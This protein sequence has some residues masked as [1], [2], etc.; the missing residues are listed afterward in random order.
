[1]VQ[2][3]TPPEMKHRIDFVEKII[4]L[5]ADA[6]NVVDQDGYITYVNRSFEEYH[7]V[8]KAEVVGKH[9]TE[10]IENTRMHIVAKSG[11]AEHDHLLTDSGSSYVVSRI[12]LIEDNECVGA[13]GLVRFRHLEEIKGLTDQI[14][15]LENELSD[16][17]TRATNPDTEY[18]FDLL[19]PISPKVRELKKQAMAVAKLDTTVLL[20]GESGTGKEVFAQSIHNYSPRR[21]GPFIYLNCSAIQENL[22]ES[23]LFGYDEG[24]FSGARKG[25]R[26]GMFELADGGT[27]FLD[28]IG[29]MPLSAQVKLLRVIQERKFIRLGSEKSIKVDVRIIAATNRDLEK[30]VREET[31]RSDLYFRLNVI[32]LHLPPLREVPEEIP[33]MAKNLWERLIRKNGMYHKILTPEAIVELQKHS[34]EGNVREL[35]NALERLTIMIPHDHIT[36]EDVQKALNCGGDTDSSENGRLNKPHALWEVLEETEKRT[37]TCALSVCDGNRSAAA[38]MLKISR[39]YLYKKMAKYQLG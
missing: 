25:G 38:K 21:E 3:M 35:R 28:E 6:L 23:E 10:V 37:I 4:D 33:P 15:N 8:R 14:K 1:M 30:M 34:W 16:L 19:A 27:L 24:A 29:D 26:R 12:P 5:A 9:V 11:T 18:T 13:L 36:R 2:T 39:P 20:R 17:K 32:P 31:F 22:I 7:N